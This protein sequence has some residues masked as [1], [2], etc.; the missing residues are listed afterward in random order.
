[1]MVI[2]SRVDTHIF[3]L[4]PPRRRLGGGFVPRSSGVV[5]RATVYCR[6]NSVDCLRLVRVASS[7]RTHLPRVHPGNRS[8]S[9]AAGSLLPRCVPGRHH[10]YP[11]H[12]RWIV[13]FV[14]ISR[15]NFSFL[16]SFLCVA[17]FAL[18]GGC[19][20][21]LFVESTA[22]LL[23]LTGFGVLTF[24]GWILYDTSRIV[25]Q[26]DADLTPAVAAFELILDIVGFH[27][28]LLDYLSVWDLEIDL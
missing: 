21:A 12:I 11:V 25:H 2:N 1:M 5:Y 3:E 8:P 15:R 17:F 22:Y 10:R 16:A 6:W 26:A 4:S 28:W 13:G 23:F 19:A 27:R 18:L 9:R 24:A 7:N 20:A 14:W